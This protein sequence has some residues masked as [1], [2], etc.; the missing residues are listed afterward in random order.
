M[1]QIN[2][3]LES[4]FLIGLFKESKEDAFAKIMEIIM[5]QTMMAESREQLG[6]ESYERNEERTDYRNGSR[7]RLLTTRIGK[8]ELEVPRHR[9][10]PFKTALFDQYKRNEQG[11]ILA[12][13]E[14]VVQGVST[15]NVEKITEQLCGA[16]FSKS[17]ISEMCTELDIPVNEFRSRRLTERYPFVIADAIYVKVRENHQVISK[18][19]MVAIGINSNGY[20]EIIG[21]NICESESEL[22]WDEFFKGLINRGLYGVDMV[23]S[24][25]HKG[26]VKSIKENFVKC[27]WQRCQVHFLRNI[28]D[29]T[30]QRY[31][32]AL[33][34]QLREMFTAPS[35]KMA[36]ETRD[37]ILNEYT[38]HAEKA[39][40][41][42]TEGFDDTM[43]IMN[44]PA[45]YRISL[46]TSNII[47]RENREIR[48]REKVIGIF[49]NSKSA[50]RLI[51]AILLDDHN[52]WSTKNKLFD[53][54]AYF[55]SKAN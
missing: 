39:M 3:T 10:I 27:A 17:T 30:P 34:S 29:V 55:E 32:A 25:A 20:K 21:F 18:A 26:L 46:R 36:K 43:A 49:P 5:N 28:M 15:R 7:K 23:I 22:S 19:V 13:M 2:F 40:N 8:I 6:A 38:T 42:L 48:R 1:A 33:S 53:M 31:K 12:M 37:N 51:G 54:T 14:M 16:K 35:L 4:D 45:K 44:L 9:E 47:E 24:D 11:L 41:I 50:I 52:D